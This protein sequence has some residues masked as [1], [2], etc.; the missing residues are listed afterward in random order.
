MLE[1]VDVNVIQIRGIVGLGTDAMLPEATLPDT[2]LAI[3][4]PSGIA[5]LKRRQSANETD[6]DGFN[7]VGKVV[8]AGRQGDHAMHMIRQH[9]PAID[10]KWTL[11]PS[12]PHRLAQRVDM[13]HQQT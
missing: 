4:A 6:F 2:P 3:A 13:V 12:Q 9:H 10:M 8:I 1:R 7:P 5:E 11:A